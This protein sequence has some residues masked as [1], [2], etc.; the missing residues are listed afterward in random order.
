M[1][2]AAHVLRTSARR[3]PG[4]AAELPADEF[5]WIRWLPSD[6]PSDEQTQC[7]ADLMA[8]LAAGA[9]TGTLLPFGQTVA[10]WRSTAEV[11]ADRGLA[12][13]LAGPFGGTG[14]EIGRAE[15]ESVGRPEPEPVG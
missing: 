6:S 15:P 8:D 11:W 3:D 7:V 1:V 10:A 14:D 12:Q 4:L 2:A 5:P 13:R 9:D